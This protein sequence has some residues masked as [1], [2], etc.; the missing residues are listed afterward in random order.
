MEIIAVIIAGLLLARTMPLLG[1]IVVAAII[2][3]CL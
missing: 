2:Y 3:R 1:L